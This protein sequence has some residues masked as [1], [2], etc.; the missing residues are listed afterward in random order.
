M[1]RAFLLSANAVNTEARTKL[2]GE[3]MLNGDAGRDI[4]PGMAEEAAAMA[5]T[6]GWRRVEDLGE[7]LGVVTMGTSAAEEVEDG[8]RDTAADGTADG[9]NGNIPSSLEKM[10]LQADISPFSKSW[11]SVKPLDFHFSTKSMMYAESSGEH[12]SSFAIT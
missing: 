6:A 3:E 9:L 12:D 2:K 1:R 7:D 10:S 8:I 4:I 11:E 5:V